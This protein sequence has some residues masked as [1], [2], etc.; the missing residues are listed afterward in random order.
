MGLMNDTENN[1]TLLVDREIL[2]FEYFGCHPCINT[3]SIRLKVSDVFNTFL[4]KVHH[5][6]TPV[7][8]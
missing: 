7:T 8:L 2:D 1:V 4:P 3:S 6:Y 5:E